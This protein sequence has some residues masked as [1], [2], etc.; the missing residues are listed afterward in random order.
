MKWL[1]PLINGLG[2]AWQRRPLNSSTEIRLTRLCSQRCRQCRVYERQTEPASMS[3]EQ[4]QL[5]AQRLR[6][7]GA[8]IGFIS[9]G[10]ATLVPDLDKILVEARRT[11]SIATT[12][13]TG[14]YN[15]T[16][17]I[18]R[19]G[20]IALE[21]NIN[22]QTSLDGLGTVGDTLRGVPQFAET[23]LRHMRYLAERRNGS[24]SL[25]YANIVLNNLNL[26]QVPEL[27]QRARD[28]GW[29]TTI[30]LYHHLTETTRADDELCL[31]PGPRLDRVLQFLEG[32]PDIMNLNSFIR[33]IDPFIHGQQRKI[34]AFVDSPI[35]T[36]RT[37]IMENGN[38]HLC[39][40]LPI[41]NIF[42]QSLQDIFSGP[43]YQQ[44]LE[45]YR[46]CPGC[47]TTCYTQRYLLVHPTSFSELID[48]F[49]KVNSTKSR[50]KAHGTPTKHD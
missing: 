28:L 24:T 14:L 45:E 48:N 37:T 32:N 49:K 33:G 19:I 18:A 2:H 44:R 30:G 23:V 15:R 16:E 35:L 4:F 17:V 40:G 5:L 7:Y 20:E 46:H 22:I 26:D 50:N 25:L 31:Q 41:G 29:K 8:F 3:Y 43:D 9:G 47:W 27:I 1:R 42:D 39:Y 36:T 13:V 34:C 6:E 38:V 11:F 10:E 21:N 12:L